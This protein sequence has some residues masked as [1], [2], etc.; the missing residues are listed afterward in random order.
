MIL[1][2]V[3]RGKEFKGDLNQVDVLKNTRVLR[4]RVG[5]A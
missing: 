3:L 4:I 5:S 1:R 2:L